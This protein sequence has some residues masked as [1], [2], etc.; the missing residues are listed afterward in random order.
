MTLSPSVTGEAEQG[1]LSPCVS[2]FSATDTSR[3]QRTLP[4]ARSMHMRVL[5]CC[6]SMAW[7]TKTRLPQ[8]MGVELPRSGRDVFQRTLLVALQLSGRF[9]S[10]QIPVPCGPRQAGQ[11]AAWRERLNR[12][13]RSQGTVLVASTERG[14]R[15]ARARRS[16][17]RPSWSK[18][19]RIVP[20]S[21]RIGNSGMT[22]AFF[23]LTPALSLRERENRPTAIGG[24]GTFGLGKRRGALHP[25]LRGEGRGE[26]ERRVGSRGTDSSNFSFV[27]RENCCPA[28]AEEFFISIRSI[29]QQ[30]TWLSSPWNNSQ[31]CALSRRRTSAPPRVTTPRRSPRRDARNSPAWHIS[32]APRACSAAW[33][34]STF[35]IA[36]RFPSPPG[37]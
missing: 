32:P 1:G 14:G 31:L 7:V 24:S 25:L 19:T 22:S 23:P 5:R 3:R 12:K 4:L 11:L 26:G 20:D 18:S 29:S 10:S 15:P 33:A 34:L 27:D 9:F 8:M 13:A 16:K 21:G 6:F 28:V 37:P 2:S 35:S 36:R 17:E 30:S